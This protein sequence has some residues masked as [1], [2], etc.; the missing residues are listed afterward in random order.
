MVTGNTESPKPAHGAHFRPIFSRPLPWLWPGGELTPEGS[1]RWRQRPGHQVQEPQHLR[2]P[3][4]PPKWG[5]A[6]A[7]TGVQKMT[8]LK[9]AADRPTVQA[10][11]LTAGP[12]PP[13]G[14]LDAAPWDTGWEPFSES[15]SDAT[16]PDSFSN[17]SSMAT[18]YGILAWRIPW[19]EDTGRLQSMGP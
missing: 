6:A 18:R 10:G 3:P 8:V 5:P 14:G 17:A 13:A 15:G 1:G 9:Q 4:G 16:P 7:S 19:T 2:A 12:G 11:S